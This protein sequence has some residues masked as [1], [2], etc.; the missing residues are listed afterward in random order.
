MKLD[1]FKKLDLPDSPG[2]YFF[3]KGKE[4]LYIGRATS[5]R[6]RVRSYFNDD[7]ISTRGPLLI[8]MV[9]EAATISYETCDSV[10]EAL[11]LE[12][13]FIKK[14]QPRYNTKEKDN[15]SFNYVAI[16]AEDFPRVLVI[17][18]RE[19]EQERARPGAK[20]YRSIFGP[21]PQGTALVEALRIVR[22]IFPFRDKCEPSQGRPCFNRQL[23]LCPGVCTGE[24]SKEEYARIIRHIALLFAGKKGKL[25]A[26]LKREMMRLAKAEQ[27]EAAGEV[28]RALFGLEH[29]NDISLIREE[30]KSPAAYGPQSTSAIDLER[31]MRIEAFD[32]AH[33]SGTDTVGV[34]TVWQDGELRKREYKKFRIRAE[35]KG[36]DTHALR[37][38]LSRR[39]GHPEWG[40]PDMVVYDGSLAQRNVV[41]EVL[42]AFAL[43]KPPEVVGVVKN[44]KHRP[45]RLLGRGSLLTAYKTAIVKVNAEAHRFAVT[46]HRQLRSRSLKLKRKPAKNLVI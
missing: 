13:N 15:K 18:A 44:S 37:E 2:V 43:E 31:P 38:L 27:F 29:V 34:M 41:F 33:I 4:I 25:T 32:I 26:T 9:S 22:K 7:L 24:I 23:G 1:A 10:L 8:D 14:H 36:S 16:T 42:D 11:I 28:K 39:F 20:R 21:Y 40:M 12:A 6:D 17:R 35:T 5:L 19:L 46:Y 45:S 3:R 30:M